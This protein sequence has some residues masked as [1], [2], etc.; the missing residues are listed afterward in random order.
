MPLRTIIF[1]LAIVDVVISLISLDT[2]IKGHR[3]IFEPQV[4]DTQ[5]LLQSYH[6]MD[7]LLLQIDVLSF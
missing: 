5:I 4:S 3:I 1:W 2:L 6:L 7:H